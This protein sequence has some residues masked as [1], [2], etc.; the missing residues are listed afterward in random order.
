MAR[1]GPTQHETRR[2]QAAK[3]ATVKIKQ[4]KN[5]IYD[6]ICNYFIHTLVTYIKGIV[7]H[8]EKCI[9]SEPGD[10]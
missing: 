8:F 9:E 7:Q 4:Q 6:F 5:T 1:C 3:V 10:R 2:V